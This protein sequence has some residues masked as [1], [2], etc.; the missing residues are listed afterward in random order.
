VVVAVVC[1]GSSFF[2]PQTVRLVNLILVH[3]DIF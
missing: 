2:L 1:Y 3:T